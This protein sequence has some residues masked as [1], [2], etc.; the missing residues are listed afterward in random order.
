MTRNTIK[1]GQRNED[2]RMLQQHLVSLGYDTNGVDGI[3]GGGTQ[4]A[5]LNMGCCG[6]TEGGRIATG[7]FQEQVVKQ[8]LI[9]YVEHFG[10]KLP[11][12][13]VEAL[14]DYAVAEIEG[15]E[16]NF[17]V[18]Q[19]W[20]DAKLGGIKDD[21]TPWCSG[22]VS[23]WI[24]RSGIR[25]ARTAW[26][27]NYLDYGVELDR[28]MLGAIVVFSRGKG[29]H[30]GFVTGIT[31]DKKQ[32]RVIGGNQSN[33]VNERMFDVSRVLGYRNPSAKVSLVPPPIVDNGE[34]SSNEA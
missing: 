20:K 2:V 32:I 7:L 9:K 3:Y 17:N 8:S 15:K 6:V 14:H 12:W 18:L 13:L 25:S 5:L 4:K 30:V 22:A 26:A 19:I 33:A 23:A 10:Q 28:P 1:Y 16:H 29:G 21:E 27:R 34:A 31:K 24:E 11:W